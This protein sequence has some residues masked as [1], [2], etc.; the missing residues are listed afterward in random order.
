MNT[1][2]QKKHYHLI[3]G[4][5]M[6]QVKTGEETVLNSLLANALLHTATNNVTMNDLGKAQKALQIG[7]LQKV[8][9][10]EKESIHIYDVILTGISSL[11]EMTD[12]EFTKGFPA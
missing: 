6:M 4:Q 12:E 3:T 11:G 1:Q 8:P 7:F 5:L 2:N 10:D 9:D